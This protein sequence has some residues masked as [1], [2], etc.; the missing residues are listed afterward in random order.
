MFTKHQESLANPYLQR[1]MTG[2]GFKAFGPF[3][4]PLLWG[5]TYM[6]KKITV[7]TKSWLLHKT[8]PK[9]NAK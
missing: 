3:L 6:Y 5:D 7:F 9:R 4:M 8:G 2:V 1:I